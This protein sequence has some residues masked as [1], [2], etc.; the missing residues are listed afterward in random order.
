MHPTLTTPTPLLVLRG[1]NAAELMRPGPVSLRSDATLAEAL[2]L[3]TARGFSAAPVIDEAGHPLGVLSQSDLMIHQR[4]RAGLK[5]GISDEACVSDLM[6]PT[7]F[8]VAPQ[9][10]AAEVVAQLLQLKIHRLF[11]VDAQGVLIGVISALDVLR[12]L[13]P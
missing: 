8:S 5:A 7:V 13:R 3:F 12:Q 6:T 4:G 9:T 11:V 10:P 2:E 1:R